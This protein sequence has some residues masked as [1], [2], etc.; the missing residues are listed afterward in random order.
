MKKDNKGFVLVTAYMVVAVLIIL[1]TSFS[2]R[3]IGEKRVAD[4]ER[5]TTQ[6][7]WLAEAGLDRAIVEFPNT[8]LSGTIGNGAYSTQTTEL[9]ST[10]YLINSTGGVPDTT[11]NPNNA[12][13][14]ISAIVERPLSPAS[15]GDITSAITASGDVEVRGSA[16]VNGTVDEEAVFTFEQVFGISKDAMKSGAVHLYTDPANNITPVDHTTWVD[17]NTATEMKVSDSGWSGSGILVVDGDM[18]ITGGHFSG[19]IWV[20]GTL[21]VSGNPIID[22][23]LFVESGAEVDTTL[24]GNPIVSFDS[25]AVGD[26]FGFIPSTSAPQVISWKED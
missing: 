9:T 20:I 3:T 19:I 14:T 7:L 2:A 24:T 21:R 4:K 15:S 11:V 18:T 5:D 16:V 8:P 17:I 10:M 23:A 26:A 1:A 13:R 12:I 25:S 22:G 6:A